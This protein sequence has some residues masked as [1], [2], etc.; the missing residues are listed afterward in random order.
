MHYG[1]ISVFMVDIDADK[2]AAINLF[3]GVREHRGQVVHSRGSY[4]QWYQPCNLETAY[5]LDKCLQAL[6]LFV[7]HQEGFWPEYYR[8]LLFTSL[9]KHFAY[10]M[11]TLK[12]PG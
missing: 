4:Q 3:L 8:P 12:A 11:N 7:T 9:G 10:C 6:H 2:Q 1:Q 5:T